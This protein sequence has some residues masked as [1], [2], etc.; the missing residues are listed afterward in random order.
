M[1]D[2]ALRMPRPGAPEQVRLDIDELEMRNLLG[3]IQLDVPVAPEAIDTK[4][5]TERTPE[6]APYLGWAPPEIVGQ[7]D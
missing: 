4:R 3:Q 7:S 1:L 6:C 2:G 5:E